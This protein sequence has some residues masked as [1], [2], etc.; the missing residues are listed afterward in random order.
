MK[1]CNFWR[2][3]FQEILFWEVG[4]TARNGLMVTS[5]NPQTVVYVCK[6]VNIP[7]K[8]KLLN[9]P[10]SILMNLNLLHKETTTLNH[11]VYELQA[12]R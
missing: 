8:M 2:E 4:V 5:A 6:S 12:H 1:Q 9:K 11:W 7:P 10:N 3:S